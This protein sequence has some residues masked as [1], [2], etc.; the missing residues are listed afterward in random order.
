MKTPHGWCEVCGG[1][2]LGVAS[3]YAPDVAARMRQT[4]RCYWHVDPDAARYQM[5]LPAEP[6]GETLIHEPML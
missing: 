1:Y 4:N 6:Q 5:C 2:W 3:G